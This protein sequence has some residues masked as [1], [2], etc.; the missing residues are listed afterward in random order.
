MGRFTENSIFLFSL[1]M[2]K[3]MAS[4]PA[5]GQLA[6]AVSCGLS[7]LGK[8]LPK[9]HLSASPLLPGLSP[10]GRQAC[11]LEPNKKP[12]V[13]KAGYMSVVD[14]FYRNLN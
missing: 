2:S 6:D 7:S 5:W 9:Q 4:S 1:E 14:M 3:N 10:V 12:Q 8:Y 13:L 11:D